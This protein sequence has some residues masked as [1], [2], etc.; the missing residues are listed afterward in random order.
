MSRDSVGIPTMSLGCAAMSPTDPDDRLVDSLVRCAFEVTA[1]LSRI[2][3][4]ND[5][6]LSQMRTLGIL[7]DR[8]AAG[9]TGL[10]T[11]L[12][13]DKSSMSGLVD[14]AERRGLVR[15]E[16]SAVDR[17]AVDVVLTTEGSALV[18][19]L[20]AELRASLAPLAE[21]LA[22]EER[23]H[24]TELLESALGPGA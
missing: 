2:G 13:L 23:T 24:L 1:V 5:L 15:R 7:R 3:A 16:R 18:T 10:A 11:H 19:R 20:Y 21:A 22:P 17:R 4:E 6:S 8:R 9:I 12:G 14:R